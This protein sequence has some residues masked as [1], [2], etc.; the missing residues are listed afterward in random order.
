MGTRTATRPRRTRPV[1]SMKHF[2]ATVTR[3]QRLTQHMVRIT[4]GGPELM[5][6]VGDGPDQRVKLFLPLA[7]QDEPRVPRHADWYQEY[8][9]MSEDIRPVMR[10]YT[11]RQHHVDQAEVDIDFVLHG[12][13]GPATRWAG[14]ARPGDCVGLYGPYADYEPT[15]ESDW[16]L[17]CGDQ[18]AL[19]AIGAIIESLPPGAHAQAYVEVAGPGEEQRFSTDGDVHITWL[20][21]DGKAAG[22]RG[23]LD[24]VRAARWPAGQ[25]YA[26]IAGES[27]AVKQLRRHLV[28][29]R[30]VDRAQ[31]YFCG[32]WRHGLREDDRR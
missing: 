15:P 3:V 7:G 1:P 2:L 28:S 6:F 20:H 13:E 26:W 22:D 27:G 18:T 17:I 8:R 30:G 5:A 11:I 25:P 9:A 19:P 31:V 23:L 32:Y 14:R 16:Q 24:A 21:R 4:F 12:D 10:T 29:E